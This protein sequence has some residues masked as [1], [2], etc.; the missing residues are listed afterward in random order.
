MGELLACFLARRSSGGSGLV[1]A[2]VF[3][4]SGSE[5]IHVTLKRDA[6]I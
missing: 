6:F 3:K 1:T 5:S 2:T 4:L